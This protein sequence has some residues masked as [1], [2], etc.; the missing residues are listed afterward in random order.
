LA[1]VKSNTKQLELLE[2]LMRAEVEYEG[3]LSILM[4]VNVGV[5]EFVLPD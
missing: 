1:V 3:V 2:R 4:E 5:K